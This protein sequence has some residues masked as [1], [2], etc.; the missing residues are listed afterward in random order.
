MD[1][2]KTYNE[3]SEIQEEMKRLENEYWEKK[4][5]ADKELRKI[6]YEAY[7]D[8]KKSLSDDDIFEVNGG[9]SNLTTNGKE[10]KETTVLIDCDNNRD[11]SGVNA[12]N[13]VVCFD[14]YGKVE[15]CQG[16]ISRTHLFVDIP[17]QKLQNGILEK[18]DFKFK[19]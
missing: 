7:N 14:V 15:H 19:W 16:W 13:D 11:I 12:T 6:V 4:L 9:S 2:A 18:S 3:L 5:S 17:A 8:F 1:I 10:L